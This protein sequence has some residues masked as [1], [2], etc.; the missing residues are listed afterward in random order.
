MYKK[1]PSF[2]LTCT[3]FTSLLFLSYARNKTCEY[4]FI[5][6]QWY[7]HNNYL[8]THTRAHVYFLKSKK[9]HSSHMVC[10][11]EPIGGMG[12]TFILPSVL[13]HNPSRFAHQHWRAYERIKS[14]NITQKKIATTV[15][16]RLFMCYSFLLS[17]INII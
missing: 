7:N 9:I 5:F 8:C 15:I 1:S 14:T 12:N 16:N 11:V 10:V 3:K 13:W 6:Y 2:S 17:I 4:F